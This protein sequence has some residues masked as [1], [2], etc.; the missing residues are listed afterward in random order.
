MAAPSVV[1]P[2][3]VEEAEDGFTRNCPETY[4]FVVVAF[5][6]VALENVKFVPVRFEILSSV[7]DAT[8]CS[9]P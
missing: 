4:R 1:V 5:V 6:E 2:V 9:P 3:I 8:L 7:D